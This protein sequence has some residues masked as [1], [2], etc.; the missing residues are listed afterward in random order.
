MTVYESTIS[1]IQRLPEP[2]IQEVNDFVEFLI[3]KRMPV[4]N[5]ESDFPDYLRNLEEYE[6]ILARGEVAW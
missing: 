3:S 5:I 1:N 2:M 4:E 6:N